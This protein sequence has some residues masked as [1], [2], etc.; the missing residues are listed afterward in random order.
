MSDAITFL[1]EFCQRPWTSKR[2][3]GVH[4]ASCKFRPNAL[5]DELADSS[6]NGGIENIT[7]NDFPIINTENPDE[8]SGNSDDYSN[9]EDPNF[10]WAEKSG[11]EFTKELNMIY[12]KIVFYKQN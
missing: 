9:I 1:C 4:K 2:G 7:L 8:N 11:K 5:G 3:L 12:D 10:L 6:N